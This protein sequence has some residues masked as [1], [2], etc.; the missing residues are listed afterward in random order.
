M[1]QFYRVIA[2]IGL[3]VVMLTTCVPATDLPETSFDES[4]TSITIGIPQVSV[5]HELAPMATSV[6]V[7]VHNSI[8]PVS[9]PEHVTVNETDVA[10]RPATRVTLALFGSFL[11]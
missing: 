1:K 9:K 10:P 5:R 4:D 8:Q 11:C 2:Q 7:P 3:L 6:Q